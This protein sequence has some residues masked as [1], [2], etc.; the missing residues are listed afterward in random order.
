[1]FGSTGVVGFGHPSC[2]AGSCI[3]AWGSL[4]AV[5][6]LL[7]CFGFGRGFFAAAFA[8]GR[9]CGRG[10]IFGSLNRIGRA[11]RLLWSSGGRGWFGNLLFG[12]DGFGGSLNGGFDWF[13]NGALGFQAAFVC[14]RRGIVLITGSLNGAFRLLCAYGVRLVFC[15]SL[16]VLPL[17]GGFAVFRLLGSGFVGFK[18]PIYGGGFGV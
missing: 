15:G 10:G 9:G 16:K 7:W 13:D 12:L 11:F 4:K 17:F 6:R 8:F 5:F 3:K 18:N 1:M 14:P 2:I